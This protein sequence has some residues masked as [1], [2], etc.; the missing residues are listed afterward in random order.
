MAEISVVA[1]F[2]FSPTVSVADEIKMIQ[3]GTWAPGTADFSG[4]VN[5]AGATPVQVSSF[6]DFLGVIAG[7][8][9]NSI[10]RLNVIT[11]ADRGLIAFGGYINSTATLSPDVEM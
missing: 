6:L 1:D 9:K 4:V 10:E 2:S 3:Q 11:H 5:K 8:A 7:S